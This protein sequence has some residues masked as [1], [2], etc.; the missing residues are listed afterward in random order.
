[1]INK[2]FQISWNSNSIIYNPALGKIKNTTSGKVI[3]IDKNRNTQ[4]PQFNNLSFDILSKKFKPIC[5]T[6]YPNHSCNLNCNYCYIF[7]GD[8]IPTQNIDMSAVQAAAEIV[9]NNCVDVSMPFILGFHGG[10]EP[11]LYPEI[12]A[13]IIEICCNVAQ[14]YNLELWPFCTTNGVFSEKIAMW[15]AST[16]YGITLSWD[17]PPE[18]HDQFRLTSDGTATSSIVARTAGI[19]SCYL[20]GLK[21]LK[22]RCT[23]TN[24]SVNN[25][26]EIVQ[27]FYKHNIKWIEFYPVFQNSD[28]SVNIDI[29]VD[30][31]EFVENF[32]KA[33]NWAKK[34][35]IILGYA[36]SRLS[37]FHDKYCPV[38]QK[39]LTLTPDGYLTCCFLKSHNYKNHNSK[40]MYGNFSHKFDKLE[41]DWMKLVNIFSEISKCYPACKNCFNYFHCAKLC[42][43]ICPLQSNLT[44]LDRE[45]CTIEKW[46][47]LANIIEAAGFEITNDVLENCASFFSNIYVELVSME[48]KNVSV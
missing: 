42:P 19:L 31:V 35:D 18:I 14:K 33:R 22:I 26:Q 9:S 38:F 24:Y 41:I 20:H 3:T 21:Q 7:N 43:W 34:Y 28:K 27:Y 36:G 47:G 16:F 30:P 29:F 10:N 44:K 25:L 23:V 17:G 32:L 46:I 15:A 45:N 8:D 4:F 37:E 13:N 12:I 11:L 5:L 6:I 2:E 48:K 1:M 39:N 40:F